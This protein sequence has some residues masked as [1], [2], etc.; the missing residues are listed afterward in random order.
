MKHRDIGRSQ[1]KLFKFLY[2]RVRIQGVGYA[3]ISRYAFY[4]SQR[5]GEQVVLDIL[6]AAEEAQ[7]HKNKPPLTPISVRL[8][9]YKALKQLNENMNNW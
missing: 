8:G 1:K 2:E 6:N 7:E 5:F 9:L 3:V 4:F